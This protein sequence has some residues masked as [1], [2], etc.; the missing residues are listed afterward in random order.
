[1]RA[2]PAARA[3]DG[4]PLPAPSCTRRRVPG[5]DASPPGLLAGSPLHRRAMLL[6]AAAAGALWGEGEGAAGT[7]AGPAH[8]DAGLL[9]ALGEM[10][11][12]A[13]AQEVLQ[14]A[15]ACLSPHDPRHE[16]AWAR[17]DALTPSWRAARARAAA[18][19]ALTAA[20]IRAKAEAVRAE[21]AL[22]DSGE[23][24]AEAD[25]LLR[26]LLADVLRPA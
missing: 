13:A 21:R 14:A 25:A 1:M 11:R 24:C 26:S 20:G 10:G 15:V 18:L 19:P 4:R 17:V 23:P 6:G 2:D 5:T 8:P 16:A 12:I 7:E 9:S 22:D 3:S